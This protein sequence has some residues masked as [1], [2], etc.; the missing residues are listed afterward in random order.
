VNRARF[1]LSKSLLQY[2]DVEE[3]GYAYSFRCEDPWEVLWATTL[4][5]DEQG[6]IRWI[7][8]EVTAGDVFYDIGASTGIYSLFAGRRVGTEGV[9]YAFEP[10]IASARSLLHNVGHNGLTGQV[11]VMSCALTDGEE[12][13][14]F[15]YRSARPGAY[16][17][18]KEREAPPLFSELKH[19][20][21]VD[22]LVESGAIQP[23]SLIK[24]DVDGAEL[25]VLEGM[26]SLL[27][28]KTP[29]SVQVEVSPQ[30]SEAVH[31]FMEDHGFTSVERNYS[32]FGL[33]RLARG[34][35]PG[36]IVHNV[37]FRPREPSA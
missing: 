36:S 13:L 20:T 7:S 19:A 23:A 9:V 4:L 33:T 24:I 1:E 16:V 14:E 12:Y 10:H 31:E 37:I 30:S 26:G 18:E 29:R 2:V 35:D 8:S 11:K 25:Q 28:E 21:S 34:D 17:P 5:Q 6:T 32:T 22:R 3:D 27:R 15:D